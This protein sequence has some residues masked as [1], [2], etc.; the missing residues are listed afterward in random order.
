M[1]E[2]FIQTDL[3]PLPSA[4]HMW[5]LD[6][7][8][9]GLVQSNGMF[10]SKALEGMVSVI[11]IDVDIK[12]N[13]SDGLVVIALPDL[14]DVEIQDV[15]DRPGVLDLKPDDK[16]RMADQ[17]RLGALWDN[18]WV[19]VQEKLYLVRLLL[20]DAERNN[21]TIT[22]NLKFRVTF[23]DAH[24]TVVKHNKGNSEFLVRAT[25]ETRTQHDLK[26]EAI[27]TDIESPLQHT[28]DIDK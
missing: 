13:T 10:Y 3:I 9:L 17:L 26:V 6:D 22:Q 11:A 28:A 25:Q 23:P 4:Q 7:D 15:T 5:Q 14:L 21:I 2:N 8:S 24:F 1:R 12:N 20:Y 19:L 18:N 27:L 16:E